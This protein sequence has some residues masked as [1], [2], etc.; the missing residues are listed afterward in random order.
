V[1]PA[2]DGNGVFVG[3][4]LGGVEEQCGSGDGAAGLG[5]DAGAGD[6][7]THGG[8]DFR[9][10]DGDDAI[11]EG[12]DVGEVAFAYALGAEAVGDGAAGEFGSPS[13][14]FAGAEAFGGVAGEFRFDAENFGL[15]TE[16]FDGGG[17]AAE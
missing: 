14:D 2:D 16:T 3:R 12:L 15:R 11:D 8:A 4:E 5:N 9:L 10:S 13:N 7:G 6:D 17:D 1:A